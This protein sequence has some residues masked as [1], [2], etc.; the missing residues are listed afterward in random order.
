MLLRIPSGGYGEL[1]ASADRPSS[2]DSPPA[3]PGDAWDSPPG[4]HRTLFPDRGRCTLLRGLSDIKTPPPEIVEC[5]GI[6]GSKIP[7]DGQKRL[8]P[9]FAPL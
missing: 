6:M 9:A 7:F 2:E 5:C 3:A 4:I 8:G 1:L